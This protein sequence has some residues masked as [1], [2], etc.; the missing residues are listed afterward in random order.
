M[1][2][3]GKKSSKGKLIDTNCQCPFC[4]KENMLAVLPYQK[5]FHIYW[6]PMFPI[7]KEF[8]VL[9]KSCGQEAPNHYIGGITTDIKKQAKTPITSFIGL[10]IILGLVAYLLLFT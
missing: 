8:F 2:I 5:S 1:I 3:Y 4:G 9:C 6:I 7:G 10:F